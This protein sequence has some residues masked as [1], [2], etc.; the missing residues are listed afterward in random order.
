MHL[1][2]MDKLRE[3]SFLNIKTANIEIES[4]AVFLAKVL[5]KCYLL[6]T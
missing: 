6:L 4:D 5:S 3:F 2:L 1:L